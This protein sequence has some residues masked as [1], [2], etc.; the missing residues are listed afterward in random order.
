MTF[1]ILP[2][3]AQDYRRMPWK[4]GGGMTTE[5]LIYPR[6]LSLQDDFTYRI[7]LAQLDQSGPFST[8]P[9]YDR[10]IVQLSGEPMDLFHDEGE[11]RA[12][13]L[14]LYEPYSF[15]GDRPTRAVLR[16]SAQD[17]NVMVKK[18]QAS[19]HVDV[20]RGQEGGR[21]PQAAA[22]FLFL[23]AWQGRWSWGDQQEWGAI[24]SCLIRAAPASFVRALTPDAL[25]LAVSL[26][27]KA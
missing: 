16:G 23:M 1:D 15:A 5:V 26:T 21:Y 20:W 25:C 14:T 27:V 22:D 6:D 12:E 2:L 9:G 24:D 7:S 10:I 17:F 13:T 19:A 3:R 8:F 4:N 11:D 18:G